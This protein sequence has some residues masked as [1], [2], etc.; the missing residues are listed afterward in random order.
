MFL[1]Q[2]LMQPCLTC[3][4][5]LP[6]HEDYRFWHPNPVSLQEL[7]TCSSS[8]GCP[9][10]SS[11]KNPVILSFT[12][13]SLVHWG[14][15]LYGIQDLGQV[16]L[17]FFSQ[18]LSL[19]LWQHSVGSHLSLIFFFFATLHGCAEYIHVFILLGCLSFID[20]CFS[21]HHKGQTDGQSC[22]AGPLFPFLSVDIGTIHL[23]ISLLSYINF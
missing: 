5:P 17:L 3:L 23:Q 10:P 15:F 14:L 19:Q 6:Q 16:S 1:R 13:K 18:S 4:P 22:D 2:S 11:H 9:S 8:Y 12:L 7:L 20:L 21:L